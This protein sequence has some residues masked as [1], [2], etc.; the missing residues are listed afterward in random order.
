MSSIELSEKSSWAPRILSGRSSAVPLFSRTSTPSPWP[1]PM[2]KSPN[3][4][5]TDMTPKNKSRAKLL[6]AQS[7]VELHYN[8]RL[9]GA[10]DVVQY[11]ERLLGKKIHLAPPAP[12]PSLAAGTKQ[13]VRACCAFLLSA[14]FTV[15]I[16]FFAWGPV[17]HERLLYAHLSLAFAT[18]VQAIGVWEFFPGTRFLHLI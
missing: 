15:P 13:T 8:A 11:Y 10:R 3:I 1:L 5:E 4:T 9:I 16:L 6:H 18:L 2:H 17:D 7:S 12:H 14:A